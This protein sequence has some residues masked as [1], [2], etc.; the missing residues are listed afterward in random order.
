MHY[1]WVAQRS[2][3]KQAGT[4]TFSQF[5]LA[6]DVGLPFRLQA[7]PT[8]LQA[9]GLIALLHPFSLI[10]GFRLAAVQGRS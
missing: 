6:V 10:I 2:S 9:A 8:L 1:G 5:I 7:R 4:P 3:S